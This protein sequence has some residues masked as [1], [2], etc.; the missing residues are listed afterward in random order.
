MTEQEMEKFAEL[1]VNKLI[2]KQAEYDA[3]FVAELT[4]TVGPEYDISIDYNV[5]VSVED[6]IQQLE[7][8]IDNCVKTDNFEAIKPLQDQINKLLNGKN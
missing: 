4:K 8:Q 5:G 1:I 2:A 3:Q 7:D 6:Q